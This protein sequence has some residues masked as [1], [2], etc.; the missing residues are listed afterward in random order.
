VALLLSLS[1]EGHA[2][3]RY[4][5]GVV[6]SGLAPRKPQGYHHLITLAARPNPLEWNSSGVN[7]SY[8]PV[9]P[10]AD[11]YDAAQSAD[12]MITKALEHGVLSAAQAR[13]ILAAA[14]VAAARDSAKVAAAKKII[15]AAKD[16]EGEVAREAAGPPAPTTPTMEGRTARES[17][18]APVAHHSSPWPSI[19][20]PY[21]ASGHHENCSP[22]TVRCV[23]RSKQERSCGS[24]KRDG[25]RKE[26]ERGRG[27]TA[28]PVDSRDLR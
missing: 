25:R 4:S 10:V 21:P 24:P 6:F 27:A 18:A 5:P 14:K 16:A 1:A 3:G 11:N 7:I 22:L 19:C 13:A 20:V 8:F 2:R 23:R 26:A 15:E 28:N 17:R 12:L 9:V